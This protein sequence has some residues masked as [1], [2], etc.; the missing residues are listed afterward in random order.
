VTKADGT[1][2]RTLWVELAWQFGGRKAFALIAADDE[3]ATSPGDLLRELFVE[4]GPCLI[5]VDEWVAYAR[6][7][8][9][10]ERSAGG[11]LRDACSPSRR[12]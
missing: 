6:P 10:P 2:V 12:H 7:A 3:N 4:S 1:V 9:R 8:P 5:L 11:R